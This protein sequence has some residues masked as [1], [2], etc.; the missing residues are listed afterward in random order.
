L[1]ANVSALAAAV[2]ERIPDFRHWVKGQYRGGAFEE[3]YCVMGALREVTQNKKMLAVFNE[4]FTAKADE[5]FPSRL[6]H[7]RDVPAFND[8]AHI[9][10]ADVRTVL[11]KLRAG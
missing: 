3:R 11:E 6:E 1:N 10:Y 9:R 8:A 5:L 7:W 2:L 4:E